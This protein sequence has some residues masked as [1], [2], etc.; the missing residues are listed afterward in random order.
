VLHRP[1]ELAAVTG[2]VPQGNIRPIPLVRLPDFHDRSLSRGQKLSRR[3]T[4]E[5]GCNFFSVSSPRVLASRPW[6]LFEIEPDFHLLSRTSEWSSQKIELEFSRQ[7][8][9]LSTGASRAYARSPSRVNG[10]TWQ[11]TRRRN[12]PGSPPRATQRCWLSP[13]PENSAAR[14]PPP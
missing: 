3:A 14:G 9:N 8:R 1:S 10:K 7:S 11:A 13:L 12:P 6:F 4:E 2:Q 5:R